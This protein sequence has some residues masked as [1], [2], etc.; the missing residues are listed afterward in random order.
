MI[1]FTDIQD[2]ICRIKK[3]NDLLELQKELINAI[4]PLGFDKHTCL[5][6]VDMNNPPPN[7]MLLFCFPEEW[8]SHYKKEKYFEDDIVLK[9]IYREA[10]PCL[11]QDIKHLNKRNQ[12]IFSE[13]QEFGIKNGITIPIIVPGHY[14]TTVNIAGEHTDVDPEAY[15]ALHLMAVHYHSAVIRIGGD[16]FK[17][18]ELTGQQQKCL[19]WAAKGKSDQ[20]IGEILFISP[21][22]V[23]YHMELV[24]AKFNVRT[25]AQVISITT[26][27]GLIFP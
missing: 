25:R 13:A 17:P 4:K 6:F 27:C 19:F 20:D 2:F 7:A 26:S 24:R 9:T 16:Q 5:S 18:P 14:P 22:T 1:D 15:H 10:K 3:I 11:W 12:M 8:V 23:N 21:R